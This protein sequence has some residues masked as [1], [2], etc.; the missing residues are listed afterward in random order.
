MIHLITTRYCLET[1]F[2][3]FWYTMLGVWVLGRPPDV[4]VENNFV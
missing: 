4:V 3:L 1:S 2:W